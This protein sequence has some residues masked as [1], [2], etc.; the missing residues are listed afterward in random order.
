M[1]TFLCSNRDK[2]LAKIN[3]QLAFLEVALKALK[4]ADIGEKLVTHMHRGITAIR[5]TLRTAESPE[6]EVFVCD[7]EDL[8]GLIC[9]GELELSPKM[10]ALL[11][12]STSALSQGVDALRHDESVEDAIK[13]ARDAVF[14]L[15]LDH[16]VTVRR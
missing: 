15:L 8:L 14:S 3:G 10:V 7:L 4:D 9:A 13:E 11:R 6:L 2:L 1:K 16:A 12:F 5:G